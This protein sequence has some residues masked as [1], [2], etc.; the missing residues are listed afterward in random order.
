MERI[1]VATWEGMHSYSCHYSIWEAPCSKCIL[2]QSCPSDCRTGLFETGPAP[3]FL[4]FPAALCVIVEILPA[5]LLKRSNLAA[6]RPFEYPDD[7]PPM[8]PSMT[9]PMGVPDIRTSSFT[10]DE[11]SARLR[12][13]VIPSL[14][15]GAS[16]ALDRYGVAPTRTPNKDTIRVSLGKRS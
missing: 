2:G 5:P 12:W 4:L 10:S 6:E 11:L 9:K 7:F 14:F 16:S 1:F 13:R 15:D 3:A 8:P